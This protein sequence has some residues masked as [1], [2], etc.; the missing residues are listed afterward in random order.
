MRRMKIVEIATDIENQVVTGI[1]KSRCLAIPLDELTDVSNHATL[2]CFVR[3]S[4][5]EDLREELLCCL[6]LPGRTVESEI[7]TALDEYFQ[8]QGLD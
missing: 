1:K 2:I 8:V 5:D 4:E 7:F 6:G 3:Y